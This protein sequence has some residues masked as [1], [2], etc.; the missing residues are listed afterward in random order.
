MAITASMLAE[1]DLDLVLIATPDHWHALTAIEAMKAGADLYLQKPISVDVAEGQAMWRRRAS[2]SASC[3]SACSA[4]ARHI[5]SMRATA[6]CAR[7][8]SERSGSS[9]STATTR[10]ARARTRPI[11]LRPHP[12]LRDV[13]RPCTHAALQPPGASAGV[14]RLHGVRQWHRR[15]HVHPHARRGALDAG[16]GHAHAHWLDRRHPGGQGQQGEHQR[17][18]DRDV[19]LRR[20]ARRLDASHLRRPAGSEVSLGDDALRRQRHAQGQRH[21]LRLRPARRRHS[22]STRT[23]STSSSSSRKTRPRRTSSATSP[24]PS[25]CT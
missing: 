5:S 4:A 11:R 8:S 24:P 9:R 10:C 14:A 19:R 21:G 17:H 1:Q 13:D 25:A 16:S 23:S 6:S 20:P 12:R 22:R 7:G 15:R 3:R 18:A 2:T